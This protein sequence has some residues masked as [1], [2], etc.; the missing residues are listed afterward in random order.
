MELQTVAEMFGLDW[1]VLIAGAAFAVIIAN[2]AKKA[3][4][5]L[6]GAWCYLPVLLVAGVFSAK[7]AADIWAWFTGTL[8]IAVIA[9]GGW[10]TLKMSLKRVGNGGK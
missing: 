2:A 9:S 6:T 1:G 5:K 4:P 10:E 7:V 3:I 8:A